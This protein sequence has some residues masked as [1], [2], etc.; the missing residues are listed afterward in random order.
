MCASARKF[1]RIGV[2]ELKGNRASSNARH[3]CSR[4]RSPARTS[5]FHT[6]QLRALP[7]IS[8]CERRSRKSRLPMNDIPQLGYWSAFVTFVA[9]AAYGVVHGNGSGHERR[10]RS[11]S[12]TQRS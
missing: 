9:A 6:I 12:Y 11:R 10:L 7:L 4:L 5:S 3:R 1:L 8:R 2:S